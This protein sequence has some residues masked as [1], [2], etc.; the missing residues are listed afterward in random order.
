MRWANRMAGIRQ[1]SS[2]TEISSRPWRLASRSRLSVQLRASRNLEFVGTNWYQLLLK[3]DHLHQPSESIDYS[4]TLIQ[5]RCRHIRNLMRLR[6]EL[7]SCKPEISSLRHISGRS[8]YL[9]NSKW[10]QVSGKV[11]RIRYCLE[12]LNFHRFNT[13]KFRLQID[14][15]D[16]NSRW[17]IESIVGMETLESRSRLLTDRLDVN[18]NGLYLCEAES[19]SSSSAGSSADPSSSVA[20]GEKLHKMFGLLV[21]GK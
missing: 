4:R 16:S 17:R 3:T 1:F 15:N 11:L 9:F 5:W 19:H 8:S 7:L 2:A 21:N 6:F 10:S 14:S 12:T 13:L 18:Q 20:N